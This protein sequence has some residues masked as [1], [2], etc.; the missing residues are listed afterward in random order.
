MKNRSQQIKR[1][2]YLAAVAL[3]IYVGIYV[4]NSIFGGYWGHPVAGRLQYSFGMS[5]PTAFL[6]QPYWGYADGTSKSFLGVVFYPLI[7]MDRSYVHHSKDMSNPQD[8]EDL[9]KK[10]IQWHPQA[11]K[12]AEKHKA[13]V[14]AW[15][16]RCIEDPEFCLQSAAMIHSKLDTHFLAVI[17]EDKFK[18]NAL[19]KLEALSKKP[20][21]EV[22][23]YAIAHVIKEVQSLESASH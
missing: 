18:T 1:S 23:K 5:L 16:S 8:D 10:G 4:P 14:A 15:R 3:V 12:E 11:V 7:I 6:W 22:D 20:D 19:G 17:L 2:F 13:E 21:S 9:S